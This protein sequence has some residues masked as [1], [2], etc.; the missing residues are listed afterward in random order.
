MQS[1]SIVGWPGWG[2]HC[3]DA[4]GWQ[5]VW[6][7]WVWEAPGAIRA[8]CAVMTEGLRAGFAS[9]QQQGTS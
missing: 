4:M 1:V 2:G 6:P 7:G 8:L 9:G 5:G 3:Q